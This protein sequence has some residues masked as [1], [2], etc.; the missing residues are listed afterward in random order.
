MG[1]DICGRNADLFRA[2]I[3]GS[4]LNVCEGCGKFGK[5]LGRAGSNLRPVEKKKTVEKREETVES[6]VPD[7][8]IKIK[9]AREK[10]KMT[11]EELAKAIAEKESVI[12]KIESKA[13]EPDLSIARKLERFFK[14]NLVI[15]GGDLDIE[16]KQKKQES[17][18]DVLT[19]GDLLSK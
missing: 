2:I 13:I 14:V 15:K 1:C 8:N 18:S 19:I 17:K 16:S 5:I 3:E 11:Q 7:Y 10:R 4:K 12:H 9:N 6:I